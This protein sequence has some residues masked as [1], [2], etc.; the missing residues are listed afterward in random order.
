MG[1]P[2]QA[3]ISN[4]IRHQLHNKDYFPHSYYVFDKRPWYYVGLGHRIDAVLTVIVAPALAGP[5]TTRRI[6]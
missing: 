5:P 4:S 3:A 1:I 6:V 2:K